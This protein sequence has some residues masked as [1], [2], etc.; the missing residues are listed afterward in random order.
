MSEQLTSV[1]EASMSGLVITKDNVWIQFNAARSYKWDSLTASPK[2][3]LKGK[4]W[5]KQI[6]AKTVEEKKW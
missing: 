3:T 5:V 6:Q 4:Y 2:Q 1:S